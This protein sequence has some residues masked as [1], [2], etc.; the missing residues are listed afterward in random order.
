MILPLGRQ[1]ARALGANLA[2]GALWKIVAMPLGRQSA[3]EV[4]KVTTIVPEQVD[5]ILCFQA[6]PSCVGCGLSL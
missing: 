3:I 6:L 2:V 5:L 1:D 4:P